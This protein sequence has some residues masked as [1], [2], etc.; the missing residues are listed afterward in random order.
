MDLDHFMML[1][2][3]YTAAVA[4]YLAAVL[5]FTRYKEGETYRQGRNG[6][7]K[8]L[9]GFGSIPAGATLLFVQDLW[10]RL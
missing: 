4:V 8:F 9:I 10:S 6:I 3:W 5:W 2:G 7:F 1:A